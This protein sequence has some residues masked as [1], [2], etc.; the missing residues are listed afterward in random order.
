MSWQDMVL[1]A[2]QLGFVVLLLRTAR[3]KGTR[4]AR[5]TSL[6][7]AAIIGEF[8]H[9]F[10]SLGLVGSAVTEWMCAALWLFLAWKRPIPPPREM[11]DEEARRQSYL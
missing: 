10:W 9:V 6:W 7:N 1:S 5:S 4:I 2:G 8:G 3:D 11:T